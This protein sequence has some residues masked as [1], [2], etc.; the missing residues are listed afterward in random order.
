LLLLL[1]RL[2]IMRA[3]AAA[4]GGAKVNNQALQHSQA[5]TW[6]HRAGRS[7]TSMLPST[8]ARSSSYLQAGSTSGQ[9]TITQAVQQYTQEVSMKRDVATAGMQLGPHATP[10]QQA[11]WHWPLPHT[12]LEPLL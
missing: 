8:N 11:A 10:Q 9:Q 1:L 6:F 3:A 4:A 5:P 12:V 7:F 2:S